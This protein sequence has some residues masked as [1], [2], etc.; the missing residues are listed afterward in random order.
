MQDRY[1]KK[2]LFHYLFLYTLS[3]FPDNFRSHKTFC[4]T[5]EIMFLGYRKHKHNFV[6]PNTLMSVPDDTHPSQTMIQTLSLCTAYTL[7][8]MPWNSLHGVVDG[9]AAWR[10]EGWEFD[11]L[12]MLKDGTC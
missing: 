11:P 5:S 1:V 9:A 12:K 10:V 2:E 3:S 7:Y 8:F 4:Y 6:L